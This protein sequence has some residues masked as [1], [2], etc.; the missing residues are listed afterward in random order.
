MKLKKSYKEFIAFLIIYVISMILLAF[1]PINNVSIM[2]KIVILHSV[3]FITLLMYIIY[4]TE[5]IY[6]FNGVEYEDALKAGSIRRKQYAYKHFI[7]FRKFNVLLA[8]YYV[9][10]YLLN[11]PYWIDII[12]GCVGIIIT[13]FSTINIEL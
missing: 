11:I 10:V 2:I 1:L 5:Y 3:T 12:I 9:I 8:L 13:A 4:K 7:R 6:W